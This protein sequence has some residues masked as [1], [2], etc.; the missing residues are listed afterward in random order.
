MRLCMGDGGKS[1]CFNET[2]RRRRVLKQQLA[3]VGTVGAIGP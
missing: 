3:E 1:S 2:G